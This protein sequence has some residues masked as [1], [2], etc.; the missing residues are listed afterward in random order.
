[1]NKKQADRRPDEKPRQQGPGKYDPAKPE[2]GRRMPEAPKDRKEFGKPEGHPM[3]QHA[4]KPGTRSGG[5][6]IFDGDRSDRESGR[7]VQLEDDNESQIFSPARPGG[8]ESE[9]GLDGRPQEGREGRKTYEAEK[10]KR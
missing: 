1:M 4:P 7:P 10:T 2:S 3:D 9:P 6:D 5:K 8:T